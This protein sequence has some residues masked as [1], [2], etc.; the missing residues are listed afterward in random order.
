VAYQS[1]Y[2]KYRPQRF[3]ELVGQEH[4]TNALRNA[5]R[6]GR[7]GHAY[8]FSGPRGTGKTTTARILAKA[9]NCTNLGSDGEPCGVCDNCVGIA[10]GTFMDLR[11]IDAASN[12]G[13]EDARDLRQK[14]AMGMGANTRHKVY[15]LDEVHMLSNDAANTLLKTLEEP[16]EHVVFVLATTNPESVLPTIRSRTQHFEFTLLSAEQLRAHLAEICR[17]EGVESGSEALTIIARAAGGSARDALSLLDQA[18]AHGTGRLETAEVAD[19]FGGAPFELRTRILGAIADEDSPTAL[20]TLG[21]LLDS[22]H[23]P[24]RVADDLLRAARDAFLLTAGG[25]RVKVDAP[26]EDQER[27]REL[28]NALG[29]AALVRVIETLGQAV[30]DMRGTDAA[31]PRLVLEV[32]LVRLSRRDAGPPLQML[33]E[34]IERLERAAGT[35]GGSGSE[36]A[37]RSGGRTPRASTSQSAPAPEPAAPA[38]SSAPGARPALGALRA[39]AP[40]AEAEPE[41]APAAEPAPTA[42]EVPVG[43]IEL[44][45]VIVAWAE[46]LPELPMATRT[47]VQTAQP[48]RLEGAVIVFGVPPNLIEAAKPRF[49]RAAD[50][51]REAFSRR[52]GRTMKFKIA[53]AEDFTAINATVPAARAKQSPARSRAEEPPIGEPPPDD[54]EHIDLTETVDAGPVDGAAS[55]VGMLERQLGATVVEEMPR[56]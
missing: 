42:P 12:R 5:V 20:V 38:P 10:D 40:P 9:L 43:D 26:V 37:P 22:G 6:D 32:A 30:V 34:R 51:I 14:V 50:S 23:E 46:I 54:D 2:R 55:S 56:D 21:E 33:V 24:R 29:N 8:L 16:P 35:G 25:G 47:A 49:H 17:Q 31:D 41:P 4:V 28:G 3:D 11:E 7:V 48:L 15:I 1:L 36:G 19:L 39:S 52:L 45:D 44:D 13:V 18:L 27:L 53:P